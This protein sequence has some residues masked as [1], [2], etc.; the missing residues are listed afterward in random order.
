M[1]GFENFALDKAHQKLLTTITLSVLEFI[2]V[3]GVDKM[4]DMMSDTHPDDLR[5]FPNVAKAIENL[6]SGVNV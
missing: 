1:K 4:V 2:L 6:S 3:E 5:V